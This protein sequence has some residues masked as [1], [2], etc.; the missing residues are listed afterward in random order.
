MRVG[1]IL[2]L[3]S[4]VVFIGYMISRQYVIRHKFYTSLLEFLEEL[5]L[6][7]LFKKEK[8]IDVIAKFSSRREL[9]EF[10]SS[11]RNYINT[12]TL[13]LT[14]VSEISTDDIEVLATL[15]TSIGRFDAN[16]E[17]KQIDSFISKITTSEKQAYAD[18]KKY[19]SMIL[20]LSIL[21]SLALGIILI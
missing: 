7:I 4:V 2:I 1:F 10:I 21:L 5:K 17:A 19:S 6:S 16:T 18:R 3:C 14:N 15:V 12:S 13:D 20:K 11:Y 9:K 8:L